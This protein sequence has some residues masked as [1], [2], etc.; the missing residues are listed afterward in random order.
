MRRTRIL[1]VLSLLVL[2][3]SGC[4]NRKG[5]REL[6]SYMDKGIGQFNR[7]SKT[8]LELK[9][10][11]VFLEEDVIQVMTKGDRVSSIA[12]LEKGDKFSLFGV[13]VG[14]NKDSAQ[15]QLKAKLGESEMILDPLSEDVISLYHEGKNEVYL[16][17]N[18][19]SGLVIEISYYKVDDIENDEAAEG[20]R[21]NKGK[22]IALIGDNRVYYNEA[23]V[24][25]KSVQDNYENEYGKGIWDANLRGDGKTFEDIIKE[26][27]INHIAEIKIIIERAGELEISITEEEAA[28]AKE[29]ATKHYYD[30]TTE[31]IDR[32]LFTE[33]I[34]EKVYIEN[35]LAEKIFEIT[36]LDVD[37]DVSD[38]E[39]RQIEL[40]F[41]FIEKDEDENKGDS[42]LPGES[43]YDQAVRLRKEAKKTDDFYEFAKNN[44]QDTVIEAFIG[45]GKDKNQDEE[46]GDHIKLL[47]QH[48]FA[49]ETGELSG[50]LE[51]EKGWYILYCVN[52]YDVD[53]TI[54]KK[55]SIINE[56]REM[57]F[58]TDFKEWSEGIEI[59]VNVDTWGKISL[60]D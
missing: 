38:E 11:G 2:V 19:K 33:E 27:V 6:S 39:A 5:P 20:D 41:I 13:N 37:T 29:F 22:L 10:N 56:R 59:V 47:K 25:L 1:I 4:N 36:T 9:A 24:Y 7:R 17:F 45:K 58:I 28:K 21:I 34:L 40:E 51:G 3:F 54:E 15:D 55:E 14:M 53:R 50:V 49:L 48:G 16:T 60:K 52:D 18:S 35:I 57:A 46:I 31:D 43:A 23:M 42:E 44:S 26:E 32:F 12:L 30:M 8:N